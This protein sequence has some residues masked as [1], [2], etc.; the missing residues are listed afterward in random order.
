MV[1]CY[2]EKGQGTMRVMAAQMTLLRLAQARMHSKKER[3]CQFCTLPVAT[4]AMCV[5][6]RLMLK[7]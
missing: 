2:K 3:S 6:D 5:L 1:E 7:V 4:S